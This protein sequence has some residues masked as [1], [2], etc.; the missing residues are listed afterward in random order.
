M[1]LYYKNNKI[2]S[3]AQ[4]DFRLV[5]RLENVCLKTVKNILKLYLTTKPK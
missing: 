3:L 5:D 4:N 2:F 1:F